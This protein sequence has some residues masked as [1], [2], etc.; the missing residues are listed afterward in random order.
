MPPN[1]KGIEDMP[2]SSQWVNKLKLI[3]KVKSIV[4]SCLN[5]GKNMGGFRK[6]VL[7]AVIKNDKPNTNQGIE[8]IEDTSL[9]Y[10]SVN[11]A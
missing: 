5:S 7:T 6:I 4:L 10:H 11:N 2:E 9:L 1:K 8:D 3:I